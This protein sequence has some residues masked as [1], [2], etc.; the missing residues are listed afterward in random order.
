MLNNVGHKGRTE[1]HR[2]ISTYMESKAQTLMKKQ[3]AKS[4]RTEEST[5]KFSLWGRR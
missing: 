2:M 1:T 3:M 4:N 5:H